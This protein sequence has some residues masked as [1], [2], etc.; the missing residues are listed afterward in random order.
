MLAG[1]KKGATPR[2]KRCE[3]KKGLRRGKRGSWS[4]EKK[5]SL[6][7]KKEKK[8]LRR[9]RK[10]LKKS[11]GREKGKNISARTERARITR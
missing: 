4:I 6:V 8:A 7:R 2:E 11:G 3:T 9:A 10:P 1:D 5:R